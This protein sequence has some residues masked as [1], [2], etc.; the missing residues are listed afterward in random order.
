MATWHHDLT[1]N[2]F[3]ALLERGLDAVETYLRNQG[4]TVDGVSMLPE[5]P[6]LKIEANAD[7]APALAAAPWPQK[8]NYA[9]ARVAIKAFM[10][11]LNA[12]QNPTNA[13]VIAALRGVIVEINR[14]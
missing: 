8:R 11:K 13:E 5:P 7:P 3:D 14:D 10:D 4:L 12:G 6:R 2:Q 9:Q 1:Q